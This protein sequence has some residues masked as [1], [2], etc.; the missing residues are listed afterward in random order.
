MLVEN[1]PCRVRG[2]GREVILDALGH[3]LDA[4]RPLRD[5]VVV[6]RE[7]DFLILL[8]YAVKVRLLAR[9]K[10]NARLSRE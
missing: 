1:Q 7:E 2:Q 10:L 9:A 4:S 6:D 3:Q 5:P 8:F